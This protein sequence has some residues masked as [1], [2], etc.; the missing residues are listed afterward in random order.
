MEVPRQ[1]IRLEPV[2]AVRWTRDSGV[3]RYAHASVPCQ[4]DVDDEIVGL[5]ALGGD[6][7]PQAPL[8]Q[9]ERWV[10]TGADGIA[11]GVNFMTGAN[12]RNPVA[13][14]VSSLQSLHLQEYA[15]NKHANR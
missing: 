15:V 12:I 9:V 10:F 1:G 2:Y 8:A 13:T 5:N 3:M 11:T 6:L 14:P 4:H 7:S